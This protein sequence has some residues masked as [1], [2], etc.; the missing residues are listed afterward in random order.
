[1]AKE[2]LKNDF[3][4]EVFILKTISRDG[5]DVIV[6]GICPKGRKEKAIE[7]FSSINKVKLGYSKDIF[8]IDYIL[9][10]AITNLSP[11]WIFVVGASIL[12]E[13]VSG[14]TGGIIG[15]PFNKYES[16]TGDI[17]EVVEGLFLISIPGGPGIAFAGTYE[18]GILLKELIYEEQQ[19]KKNICKTVINKLD[20]ITNLYILVNDGSGKDSFGGIYVSDSNGKKCLKFK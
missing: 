12:I 4:G 13:G 6:G 2:K 9:A 18:E 5:H 10:D 11:R 1:M 3:D 20:E 16:A 8:L 19:N 15:N 7:N 17:E 14:R